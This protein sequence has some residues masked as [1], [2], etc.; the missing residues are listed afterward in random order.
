MAPKHGLLGANLDDGSSKRSKRSATGSATPDVDE[1]THFTVQYPLMNSK[2][3]LSKK[4]QELVDHAEFQ[5][6]PFVPKGQEKSELDQ[7]YTITPIQN[8]SS[9]KKYNN[10]IIQGEI[11]KS[12]HFVY[13]KGEGTT[14][15]DKEEHKSF[16]VARIL[17]VRAKDP[18]HV[19][20]LVAWMYWREQLPPAKGPDVVNPGISGQRTYHGYHELIASNYMDVLDVLSFA[21]K[22]EVN[23]WLEEGN[24]EDQTSGLYWRQTFNRETG[25]LSP[26]KTH[27]ICNGHSNPDSMMF[28][29]D[30]DTCKIWL[31]PECLIDDI[32]TKTYKKLVEGEKTETESASASAAPASASADPTDSDTIESKPAVSETTIVSKPNGTDSKDVVR[33]GKH[34][35]LS[36]KKIYQGLFKAV[37]KDEEKPPKFEIT[38]LRKDSEGQKTWL[39]PI[40]CPKCGTALE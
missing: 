3:K 34:G 25:Q 9:M 20:A 40:I 1:V 8:W 19:Y 38:D 17:Q 27:C 24:D 16:W 10:F 7:Y 35:R 13:V 2:R 22:A 15:K 28:V 32:L 37:I 29:C 36:G 6:S 21:G 11:Y 30:N 5:A 23:H 4:E 33:K 18:Q 31:H 12:N 26:I 39:E 14:P